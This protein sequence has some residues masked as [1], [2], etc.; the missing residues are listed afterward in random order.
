MT[1]I[2]LQRSGLERVIS[3]IVR[4]LAALE[5]TLANRI[6][7]QDKLIRRA[8]SSGGESC[9]STSVSNSLRSITEGMIR[10]EMLLQNKLSKR[11]GGPDVRK[12]MKKLER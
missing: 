5:T 10:L 11:I 6:D 8:D 1:D 9:E 4:S 7:Y 3:D 2:S 12:T